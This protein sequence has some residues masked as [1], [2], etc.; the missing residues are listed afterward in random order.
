MWPAGCGPTPAEQQILTSFFRASRLRDR[1][2]LAD[3]AAVTF[4]PRADG[5]V[6]RFEVVDFGEERRLD[7]GAAAK[8]VTIDAEVRTPANQVVARRLVVAMQ[9]RPEERRWFITGITPPPASRT[10]PAASSV[11][12]N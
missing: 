5:V 1:T 9:R 7:G 10:S 12:P 11:P 8:E 2:V 4:E 6:Q 3:I